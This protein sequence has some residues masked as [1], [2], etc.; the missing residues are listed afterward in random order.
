MPDQP[1]PHVQFPK[2]RDPRMPPASP[3][4]T[5]TISRVDYAAGYEVVCTDPA[6]GQR[7]RV[8]KTYTLLGMTSDGRYVVDQPEECSSS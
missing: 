4:P 2:L 7:L 1:E 5:S 3:R 6:T 8:H